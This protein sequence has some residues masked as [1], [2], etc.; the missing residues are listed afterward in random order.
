M[1]DRNSTTAYECRMFCSSHFYSVQF[2][3]FFLLPFFIFN[4]NWAADSKHHH[5]EFFSNTFYIFSQLIQIF[6]ILYYSVAACFFPFQISHFL[7]LPAC[8][9]AR[10][11]RV[12][13]Y[14]FCG[15]RFLLLFNR[16]IP[17]YSINIYA[18]FFFITHSSSRE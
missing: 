12:S 7:F 15:C 9:P 11:E 2:Q 17:F 10:L 1:F 14:S 6:F 3:F 8:L 18:I 16:H 4:P 13:L 5:K